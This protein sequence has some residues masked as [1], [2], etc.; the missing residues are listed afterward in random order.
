MVWTICY[1]KRIAAR[2]L[3]RRAGLRPGAE[4]LD[5]GCGR[6][7][8]LIEAARRLGG[9]R[10]VGLDLWNAEDLSGNNR[11]AAQSNAICEGVADR[12]TLVDGDMRCMP[13]EDDSFDVVLSSMAVHNIYEPAGRKQA[14]AEIIRVLRP[15]GRGTDT[16]VPPQRRI[17][18]GA[19]G[20][21]TWTCAGSWSIL[22]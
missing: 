6:G 15:G 14:L 3:V 2:D 19:D 18:A 10:A 5:V 13:F 4:V 17:R 8:L 1:G 16:G 21:R 9:G 22:C 20:G 7:L 12:V 11:A